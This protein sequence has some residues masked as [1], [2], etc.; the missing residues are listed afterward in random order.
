[1]VSWVV[2]ADGAGLGLLV[3]SY[4]ATLTLRW[5]QGRSAMGGRS[6]CDGCGRTLAWYELVPLLSFVALRGRC[7]TCGAAIDRRHP[8]IEIAAAL[9][10]AAARYAAPGI[11]G[12]LGAAFGWALLTLAVLDAEHFW[13]P[14]AL[15][16]PLAAAG[17]V[18][19]WVVAPTPVDR[20]L[21]AV[22]GFA[23][24][25]AVAAVYRHARGRQGLGGGDPKL[26]GAIGAWLGWQALPFVLLLA[27]MLGLVMAASRA[28]RG[29]AVTGA[30]RL[31][32]GAA[33]AVAAWAS[34]LVDPVALLSRWGTGTL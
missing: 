8:T 11:D 29:E 24:L 19:G 10:G 28:A 21:G 16:L 23:S 34:W 26:F 12:L 33:L 22:A 31:P 14:N 7:R 4:V 6:A 20:A 25:A 2:V 9:I 5:P 17:L 30:T 18:A 27:A 15:T 1:M 3:G 32:F 13:L